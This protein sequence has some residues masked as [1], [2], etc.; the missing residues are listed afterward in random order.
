MKMWVVSKVMQLTNRTI[1]YS[2]IIAASQKAKASVKGLVKASS[3][4]GSLCMV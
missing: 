3:M 1:I 4:I 2:S